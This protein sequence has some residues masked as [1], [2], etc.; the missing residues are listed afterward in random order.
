M[1]GHEKTATSYEAAV[2]L[3]SFLPR[4]D[5][6]DV[7]AASYKV[8]VLSYLVAMP[9]KPLSRLEAVLAPEAGR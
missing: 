8:A 6:A 7:T 4:A 2:T 3:A 9:Q 5:I 1:S